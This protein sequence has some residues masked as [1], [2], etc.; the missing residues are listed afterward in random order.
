MI[1]YFTGT[2]NSRYCAQMLADRLSDTCMDTFHFIRNGIAA[3]LSSDKPWVFVAPTYS[4]KLPRVFVQFLRSGTFSGNRQAYF[5]MTCGGD[6]GNAAPENQALCKE[7]GL[8]Y[9]GTLPVVMPENYIAMFDVPEPAQARTIIAAA[10]PVLEQAAACIREGQSFP[11][12]QV[13]L[14]DRLKSGI[15]NALFYRFHVRT[16]PFTVSDA[17]VSCGRCE[18]TCPLD[19]IRLV[20]G[21]PVWGRRCTHCMSCICLCPV[22][23]IEYGKVSRGKPQYQCPAYT[24]NPDNQQE[25]IL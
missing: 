9:Q 2:G 25:G 11:V 1:I 16:K 18:Q 13:R 8:Q 15:V 6:I 14:L 21:K 4:W 22:R 23:A 10:H 17:C 7:K 24:D 19:N 20:Q 3:E 5:I 12:R